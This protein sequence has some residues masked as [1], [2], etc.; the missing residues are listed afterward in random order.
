MKLYLLRLFLAGSLLAGFAPVGFSQL[1]N[2]IHL[3]PPGPG[4]VDA[5]FQFIELL[6]VNAEGSPE[7]L[8]LNNLHLILIDSNGGSVGAIVEVLNLDG[9]ETGDNGLVVIGRPGIETR[10]T[11]DEETMV[12]D[13][14]MRALPG[15]RGVP[16]PKGG[17][18]A[19][20]VRNFVGLINQDLD[21]NDDGLLD[22]APWGEI[23]DS[24][25]FGDRPYQ[26]PLLTTFSPDNIS[27]ELGNTNANNTAAFYGGDID[28]AADGSSATKY[29]TNFFGGFVGSATPGQPNAQRPAIN[30]IL[31]NEVLINPPGNDDNFE[32]IE[33]TST[34]GG[35]ASADGLWLVV[36]DSENDP[37]DPDDDDVGVVMEA[38]TLNGMS[39]GTNGLLLLGNGYPDATPWG[40]LVDRETERE[41]PQQFGNRDIGPNDGFT[42]FLVKDF[43]GFAT[44]PFLPGT[45]LDTDNDGVLDSTPWDTSIGNNGILDSVGFSHI[46]INGVLQARTYALMD[47][48]TNFALPFSPDNVSRKS[49]SLTPNDVAAWYGG[50]MGGKEQTS[51]SFDPT[52]GFGFDVFVG[53][54]TPGTGN[55]S[56]IP[57]PGQFVLN[58]IHFDPTTAEDSKEEF[59][60][61]RNTLGGIDGLQ[62]LFLVIVDTA[63]GATNGV[64]TRIVN[65]TALS[66]G[67]NGLLMLQDPDGG[68]P[69][70]SGLP[71]LETH[72][73]LVSGYAA[74]G[75]EPDGGF[76]IL[77]AEAFTGTTGMDLD[78]NDDGVFDSQPWTALQDAVGFGPGLNDP[79]V[80]NLTQPDF[81][82]ASVARLP[83]DLTP[84]NAA[85]WY[86]GSLI[87]DAESLTYGDSFGPFTGAVTPGTHNLSAP[88]RTGAVL[89]NEINANP[90]GLDGNFEFIEL[91]N[92]TLQAESTNGLDLLLIDTV[93]LGVGTILEVWNLDGFSTGSNGLLLLGNDYPLT[94][95][96]PFAG[97][98]D[99][100]TALGDPVGLGDDDVGPNSNLTLMLVEGFTG[101]RGEDLDADN[102][103][104]LDQTPWTRIADSVGIRVAAEATG[105]TY[106]LADLSQGVYEPDNL[107]REAGNYHPNEASA[108]YGGDVSGFLGS[109]LLFDPAETFGLSGTVTPGQPNA[110]SDWIDSDGDGLLGIFEEALGLDPSV[111]STGGLPSSILIEEDG[112]EYEGILFNRLPADDTTFTYVLEQSTDLTNWMPAGE[113]LIAV[114]ALEQNGIPSPDGM[115]VDQKAFRWATSIA[116]SPDR[117][118]LRL[119]VS[120]N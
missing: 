97:V 65:L 29:S 45:D 116:D 48:T 107:S 102:N 42:L 17:I 73:D 40:S 95:G 1:I 58:E 82:I 68:L 101:R 15:G 86:G 115:P 120:R 89:L 83:Q 11:F 94:G 20:I 113:A 3:N 21:P 25:S 28:A 62:G 55:L 71:R 66:T 96:G 61:I 7:K 24:V 106:A 75:L 91:I 76:A 105:F 67:S 6:T 9:V 4:L 39:T 87:G 13:Y 114:P 88:V 8:T 69:P 117:G 10:F 41:D 103:K 59:V 51:I 60:E 50:D 52:E 26:T 63:G 85:A 109:G 36:V 98:K 43:T 74:G 77:L 38:W 2:E 90:P 16:G 93:G 119:K 64:V 99:A 14:T 47:L 100:A 53:E 92:D 22:L 49:G 12:V 111:H 70:F 56:G 32:F 27:R 54:A 5:D 33:L 80:A 44:N 19:L 57:M 37:L 72:V 110:G 31:I 30:P 23:V 118:F 112:I 35:V 46:D 34:T 108:W 18:T 84:R 81:D 78:V 104:V 79:N